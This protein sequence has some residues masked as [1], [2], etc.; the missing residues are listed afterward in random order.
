MAW[1][2]AIGHITCLPPASMLISVPTTGP[3]TSCASFCPVLRAYTRLP[4]LESFPQSHHQSS[5]DSR[6]YI[7]IVQTHTCM[8]MARCSREKPSVKSHPF[9]NSFNRIVTLM[10]YGC[11]TCQYRLQELRGCFVGRRMGGR[12]HKT[13]RDMCILSRPR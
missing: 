7:S 5:P 3:C 4:I 10:R 11:V 9:H 8:S 2:S 1:Q 12:L 6:I 13:S